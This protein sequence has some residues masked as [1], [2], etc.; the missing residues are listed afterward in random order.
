MRESPSPPRAQIEMKTDLKTELKK[1]RGLIFKYQQLLAK[2]K[3]THLDRL[4]KLKEKERQL[5]AIERRLSGAVNN[6]E[7][8]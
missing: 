4:S 2:E 6:L 5:A 3:E 1:C 7:N 8:G